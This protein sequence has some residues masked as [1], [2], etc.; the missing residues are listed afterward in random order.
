M[1]KNQ[2]SQGQHQLKEKFPQ[3]GKS[4]QIIPSSPL[5]SKHRLKYLLN[6][7]LKMHTLFFFVLFCLKVL[8]YYS[9]KKQNGEI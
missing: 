3:L 9:S 4:F 2:Y 1:S 7:P 5:L 8:H 6:W